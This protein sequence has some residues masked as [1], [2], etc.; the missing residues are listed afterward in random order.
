MTLDD[1]IYAFLL[2]LSLL[3][4][5]LIRRRGKAT[6][7]LPC[8]LG[9]CLALGTIGL[10]VWHSLVTTCGFI[11]FLGVCPPRFFHYVICVWCFGYLGFFRLC[12][13]FGFAKPPALA[14]A[15]Q[16]NLTL[17]LI[18]LSFE[19]YDSWK[20]DQKLG[21]LLDPNDTTEASQLKLTRDYKSVSVSPVDVIC[22][23]YCYIGLFTVFHFS[24]P[25]LQYR[26]FWDFVYW[27]TE[28]PEGSSDLLL[29]QLQE[30]PVFG[31]AYLILSHF[32][33]VDYVRSD[34]FSER[35]FSYRFFYMSIIFFVFRLRIYFAWKAAECVC[36]IAGL[37]AYPAISEPRSGEGP[38]NLKALKSW[39]CA[40]D[41]KLQEQNS[42]S[43]V[44]FTQSTSNSNRSTSANRPTTEAYDYTTI[45]NI[46]VWGCE[47]TPTVREGMHSW[48]QTV[49]YWLATN[50]HKRCPGNRVLRSTWTML[51][52]AY[53]HGLHP[54]YYLSFMIIPLALVAES[55][56]SVLVGACG[57]A[58]PS[59]SLSFFSWILKMRV[60][61]YCAMGFLLLDARATWDYWH[62]IG[63]SVHIVLI[64]V[65]VLSTIVRHF[66]P[67]AGSYMR[68]EPTI[69][70]TEQMARMSEMKIQH[71][72]A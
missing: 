45:Q 29:Q 23:A 63:F 42:I 36:M 10:A 53:W 51:L 24:W 28:A 35:S 20:T 56:L 26:T 25:I 15:I 49:Q 1:A 17:R 46:S 52:S 14:N 21:K 30:A 27:P 9:I 71:M 11:F 58:L 69:S 5:L 50:F 59:G 16:L 34:E 41:P 48:N 62:S 44:N 2:F 38:T 64:L 60:F 32:Y 55:G 13:S 47:F 4:G 66:Y 19:V 7:F 68:R 33:G 3:F 39:M 70:A 57:E 65:I 22:Y 61:E 18:G 6:L 8:I 72:Q 67:R 31:V 12:D 37:G 43:S 54:G 40:Y